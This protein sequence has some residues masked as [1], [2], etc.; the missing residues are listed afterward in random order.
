[1]EWFEGTAYMDAKGSY[2]HV[3]PSSDGKGGS[4]VYRA[5]KYL[6]DKTGARSVRGLPFRTTADEAQ[7]DLDAMA[8][9]KGWQKG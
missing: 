2:Y 6:P 7:R 9:R 8:T 5:R 1:M 4:T 3:A